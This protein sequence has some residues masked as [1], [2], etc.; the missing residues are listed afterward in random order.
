MI[1]KK[2]NLEQPTQS[3]QCQVGAFNARNLPKGSKTEIPKYEFPEEGMS[4][5]AAYQLVH[6]QLSLDG[7]PLLNLASF[8][9]TWMEPEAEKLIMENINKN[10]IDVFEYP[11]ISRV[12]HQNIVNT[13]GRLFNGHNTEFMGTATAGSSEAIM[14]GL[15]AHKWNWKISGRGTGKPNIIFGADAHVSW[16]KFARYFDVDAIKI[17]ISKKTRIITAEAVSKHIDENTICVGCVL[18]TT[19]T[20]EIDPIKEINDLL[21]ECKR[22]KNWNIPI[23]VDA[24]SGGFILPFTE[25]DLEW[26]FRLDRVRSINIPGTSTD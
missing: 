10:I 4:P 3:I 17:P 25:P 7:N 1:S 11:Q 21:L 8:V 15:L 24:A 14:L 22:E 26:D 16:D 13:L 2:V 18:G 9:N 20:G 5:R 23:H 19:Y 6:N 12:I